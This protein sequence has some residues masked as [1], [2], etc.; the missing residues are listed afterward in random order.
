MEEV[1]HFWGQGVYGKS[2]YLQLN[3]VVPISVQK[4]KRLLKKVR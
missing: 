3:F 1:T 2:R 4:I